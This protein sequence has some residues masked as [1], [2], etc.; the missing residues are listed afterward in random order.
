[1]IDKAKKIV[2]NILDLVIKPE[3]CPRCGNWMKFYKIW[4]TNENGH[5]HEKLERLCECVAGEKND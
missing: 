1:M 4:S 5:S 2:Y 3:Q